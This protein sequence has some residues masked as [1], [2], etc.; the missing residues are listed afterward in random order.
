MDRTH[1]FDVVR[2]QFG[3]R[4][5]LRIGDEEGVVCIASRVLLWLEERVEVPE[6][7]LHKIVGGHLREAHLE[8]D[9]PEF[10]ADLQ[11]RMQVAALRHFTLRREAVGLE[12]AI[13][14][15]T[16]A[17]KASDRFGGKQLT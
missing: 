1:A 2:R 8:E 17:R 4:R 5:D 11:E 10:C 16:A 6:A 12:G 3:G 7:G 9:G 14:P 13:P 15:A